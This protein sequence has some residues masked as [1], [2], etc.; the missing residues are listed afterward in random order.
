MRTAPYFLLCLI[1]LISCKIDDGL[2]CQ[3]VDCATEQI[4]SIEYLDDT[5]SNLIS[6][7][8]YSYNDIEITS[9]NTRLLLIPLDSTK[10]I[11]FIIVGDSIGDTSYSIKLNANETDTLI[12]N[13]I[14]PTANL[15]PCCPALPIIN[16]AIYNENVK[17]IITMDNGFEKI[18]I[19]K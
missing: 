5:G 16:K 3:L 1:T 12:L 7:E 8:T 11:T 4:F 18:S 15:N 2:D 6:N 13:T 19:I 14:K 9:G 17:D 10:L